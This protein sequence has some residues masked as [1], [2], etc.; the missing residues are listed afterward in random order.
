MSDEALH[1]TSECCIGEN[2]RICGR[3]AAHKVEEVIFD[4]D[5]DVH[6]HPF[7]AYLCCRHFAAVMGDAVPC[8]VSPAAL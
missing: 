1:P 4:D 6:R 3:P 5:P 8:K 2:C 7:T